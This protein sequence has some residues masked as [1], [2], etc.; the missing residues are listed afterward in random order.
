MMAKRHRSLD[1]FNPTLGI[2]SDA[3]TDLIDARAMPFGNVQNNKCY[4]GVNQKEYGTS[5]FATGSA[6]VITGGAPTFLFEAQFPNSSLLQVHTPLSVLKYTAGL[7]GYV[8]DGQ[9]FAGTYADFWSGVMHN[10]AYI[11]S[12]G[13]APLQVKSSFSA[14]GT[15][16]ASAV[17]PTTYSAWSL[18]SMRDHL[19]L[20][21]TF[22]NGS[23]FYKRVRWSKKGVLT[24]T[25]ATTDFA[26]GV[27]GSIDIQDGEGELK[28]AVPLSGGAALYFEHCVHYQFWVGGDE[29]WRFQKVVPGIGTPGRRTAISYSDV[30]YFLSQDNVYAFAGGSD[31]RPIGNPIKQALFSE[32]NREFINTAF[33]DFD[34]RE[35]ELSINVPTGTA[36]EP[37]VCWVYRVADD[38]WT[39]KIRQHSASGRFSRRTGLT[40]GELVGPIGAQNWTFGEAVVR[41]DAEVK[42]FGDPSGRIVKHDI[43]RYSLSQTG[44]DV[45]QTF[46]YET[47]DLVGNR[48]KFG[49]SQDPL[50]AN[51]VENLVTEQRWQRFT[52]NVFGNGTADV[53]FST[54]RGSTFQPFSASPITIVPGA[55]S[56]PFDVDVSNPYFRARVV[57]TGQNE[58]IGIKYAKVDFIP[59]ANQ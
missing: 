1:I 37:N 54:D 19:L 46:I 56:Y 41:V 33:L 39:R 44:T 55:T 5:L 10:D 29:V 8:S 59:G 27:A 48:T 30:N 23:E 40:I 18:L 3:P 38:A 4:Y 26:S 7:D 12:N 25:A 9:A 32:I 43:A 31:L 45:A 21:H 47:P 53:L 34:P 6:A 14:T 36:T 28:C 2:K 42:L 58:F 35:N 51:Y 13:L 57:N 20:Y 52:L 24:Y 50:E 16:M 17:S 22:E 15:N 49:Y 11:Y